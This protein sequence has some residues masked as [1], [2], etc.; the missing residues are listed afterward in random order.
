M[1]LDVDTLLEEADELI[2]SSNFHAALDIYNSILT[3]D[4]QCLDAY[5]MRGAIHGELGNIDN[6]ISDL[7]NAIQIEPDNAHTHLAVAL[8]YQKAGNVEKLV[9]HCETALKYNPDLSEAKQLLLNSC[10]SMAQHFHA[11][12]NGVA[13]ERLYSK[14][15][16]YCDDDR[17]KYNAALVK[18]GIGK[19]EEAE[20]LVHSIIEHDNTNINARALLASIYERT[21]NIDNGIKLAKA[22]A[23]EHPDHSLSCITYAKYTLRDGNY[24][25][26][27]DTLKPFLKNHSYADNDKVSFFMTLGDLY[28][29]KGEYDT[30]FKAYKTAN[31]ALHGNYDPAS[32]V[33]YVDNMINYFS[34][35][36]YHQLPVSENDSNEIIYIVGMPRSGSTLVEQILSSHPSVFGSG[37]TLTVN[38]TISEAWRLHGFTKQFPYFISDCDSDTLTQISNLLLNNMRKHDRNHPRITDKFLFN[39]HNLGLLHKLLPNAVFINCER[40]PRDTCLSCYF[41][42][43][44]GYHPYASNLKALGSQYVQYK[45]LMTHWT[46]TLGIPV[47]TIRYE[48]IVNQPE[49]E[50]NKLLAYAKLE[51]DDR[52]YEFYKN[53]RIIGTASYN[54]A[55]KNIYSSSIGRWRNYESHI[56]ELLVALQ[57]V[58]AEQ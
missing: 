31:D 53:K 14:A 56:G 34:P 58:L 32:Y 21:G 48:D 5:L 38:D 7:L 26:G 23:A 36:S 55:N 44:G 54:Q 41:Q 50:I 42:Y 25:S 10:I 6:G 4:P 1:P 24:D 19:L 30:A 11:Q 39:Y 29:K 13:A 12:G 51:L 9:H 28:D 16:P 27:I 37:E 33:K 22:L 15:L 20:Q 8:L 57:P 43:F 17:V 3:F 46:D 40:D 18:C 45:R 2:K 49:D 47:Y 35:E 52:C